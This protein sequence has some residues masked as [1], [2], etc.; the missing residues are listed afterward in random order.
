LL[1]QQK[2]ERLSKKRQ[3]IAEAE[4]SNL[5][6]ARMSSGADL[7]FH[8]FDHDEIWAN[9][10]WEFD[11]IREQERIQKEHLDRFAALLGDAEV[12]VEAAA[13]PDDVW[14]QLRLDAVGP[15]RWKKAV[16]SMCVQSAYNDSRTQGGAIVVKKDKNPAQ[17][18]L[19]A[20]HFRQWWPLSTASKIKGCSLFDV[21]QAERCHRQMAQGNPASEI[22]QK[23]LR[24]FKINRP[25]GMALALV[26]SGSTC[27]LTP[28]D[29]HI[30]GPL[31]LYNPYYWYREFHCEA[32]LADG[33]GSRHLKGA[34]S[35]HGL[36]SNL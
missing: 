2:Q 13:V 19:D 6:W 3:C 4:L 12:A 7:S 18:E 31:C 36:S 9:N 33:I 34:V 27:F 23:V 26:D 8:W 14:E 25:S 10:L 35:R 5:A 17:T 29:E 24:C 22:L 30:I 16:G 15:E 21:G 1:C 28:L 32:L 20:R 11:D